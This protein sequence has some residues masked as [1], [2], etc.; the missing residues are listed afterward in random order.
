MEAIK[1]HF[2][3]HRRHMLGCV[4]GVLIG[5][6]GELAHQP[7]VA[8]AGAVICAGFCVQMLRTMVVRPKG[9]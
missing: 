4:F 9:G 5:V 6:I 2:A 1:H 8:I 3:H 7:M